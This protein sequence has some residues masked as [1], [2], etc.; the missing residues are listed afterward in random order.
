MWFGKRHF[1][2]KCQVSCLAGLVPSSSLP[3]RR[4]VKIECAEFGEPM[5]DGLQWEIKTGINMRFARRGVILWREEIC[6]KYWKLILP[7]IK[8]N[9]MTNWMVLKHY[10]GNWF[11]KKGLRPLKIGFES[12][13]KYEEKIKLWGKNRKRKKKREKLGKKMYIIHGN[14]WGTLFKRLWFNTGL[15][16]F[17]SFF[18]NVKNRGKM[19]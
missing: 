13:K 11:C 10:F 14:F 7:K 19:R 17:L 5:K 2:N 9:S 6:S 8:R 18:L 3:P 15:V 12:L 4:R 1:R 16:P